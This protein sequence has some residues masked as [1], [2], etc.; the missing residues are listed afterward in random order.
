MKSTLILF[1]VY[2]LSILPSYSQQ[3]SRIYLFD[4]FYV[5]RI[6]FRNRSITAAK[7]NYDAANKTLLY[8][9]GDDLMELTNTAL[10]DTIIVEGRKLI[11]AESCYYEVV[12]LENGIVYI[13]WLLKDVNVGSKGALGAVTQG[14]VH[15]VQMTDFGNSTEQYTP[16]QQQDLHVT[17]V[18]KRKN[19]NTYLV[20]INGKLQKINSSKGLMKAYSNKKEEI[21]AYISEHKIDFKD[22]EQALEVINYC[23]GLTE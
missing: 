17:D 8:Y 18:L 21:K 3:F 13:D 20:N 11:P 4:D 14:S 1:F 12:K 22:V 19:D 5:G 9:Q 7:L 6:K 23:M 10:V 15:N 16:Y 2:V